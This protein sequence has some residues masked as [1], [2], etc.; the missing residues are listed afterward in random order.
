VKNFYQKI[1]AFEWYKALKRG[2]HVME[3]LLH[4]GRTS[5][6]ATEVNIAKV[7]KIVTENPHSTF[8]EIATELFVSHESISTILTNHLGM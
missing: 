6:F 8:T 4:S 7:K 1:V 5:T 2:R 3:D